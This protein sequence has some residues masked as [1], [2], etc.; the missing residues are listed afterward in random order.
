[1]KRNISLLI[2]IIMGGL[3]AFSF[4]QAYYQNNSEECI[5]LIMS[6]PY[7]RELKLW[8]APKEY[9][10]DM[11]VM[12]NGYQK[13]QVQRVLKEAEESGKSVFKISWQPSN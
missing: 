2:G 4:M 3:A 11:P 8:K 6:V 13:N 9:S 5:R 10:S 12:I 7:V 1:M